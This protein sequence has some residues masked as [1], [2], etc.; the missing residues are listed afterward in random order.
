LFSCSKSYEKIEHPEFGEQ[1]YVTDAA[2]V[3]YPDAVQR[4]TPR[5]GPNLARKQCR[6]LGKYDGTIWEDPENQYSDFSVIKFGNFNGD[7]YFISFFNLDSIASKCESWQ[8]GETIY[9]GIKWN[10]ELKRDQEDVLWFDYDYYGASKEIEYA[11]SYKYEVIDGLLHFSNTEGQT[12]I[13]HPSE[14]NYTEDSLDT[15]EIV[16]LPGCMF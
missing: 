3:Q 12:F 13:F 2:G 6:F 10:I 15:E 4:P 11:I 1:D 8:L 5:C 16:Y 7:A 14:R 9:N